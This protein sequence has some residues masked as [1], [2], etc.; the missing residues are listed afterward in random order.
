MLLV[1]PGTSQPQ[2]SNPIEDWVVPPPSPNDTEIVLPTGNE[3]DTL[4][5]EGAHRID[6]LIIRR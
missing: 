1:G 3:A 6:D 4:R 2:S 5:H